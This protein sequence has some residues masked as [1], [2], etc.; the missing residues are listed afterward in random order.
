MID[1]ATHL[2]PGWLEQRTQEPEFDLRGWS[3]D[4]RRGR[5]H[6]GV[7]HRPAQVLA[8]RDPAGITC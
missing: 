1:C 3:T 2:A 4:N 8:D 7:P 5:A 6:V